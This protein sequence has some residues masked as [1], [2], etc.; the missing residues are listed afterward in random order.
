MPSYV[1]NKITRPWELKDGAS[2][3][4]KATFS[5]G[6]HVKLYHSTAWRKL[7]KAHLREY[8]LCQC[9][10]CKKKSVPKPATITDHIKPVK[11]GGDF[12]DWNNLQSLNHDCHNKKS[13]KERRK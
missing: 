9:D 2:E 11:D 13:A 8:P 10:N 6:D 12:W 4:T 5:T 1:A 3:K 7:S